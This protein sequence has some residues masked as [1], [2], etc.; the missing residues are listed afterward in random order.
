VYDFTLSIASRFAE[1]S[2]R[3]RWRFTSG[4]AI[5]GLRASLRSDACQCLLHF[6]PLALVDSSP[7]LNLTRNPG[8]YYF[9]K[10]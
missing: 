8:L 2:L 7:I 1:R 3:R 6:A 5:H 10:S 9:A 4:G